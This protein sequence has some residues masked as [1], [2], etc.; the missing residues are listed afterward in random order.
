MNIVARQPLCNDIDP[1]F[2]PDINEAMDLLEVM[3]GMQN[4]GLPIGS[5]DLS[6]RQFNLVNYF[7]AHLNA[8]KARVK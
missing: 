7:S 8:M 5:N 1:E 3:R 6:A 4:L 2:H